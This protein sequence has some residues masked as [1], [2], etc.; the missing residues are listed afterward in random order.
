MR[1]GDEQPGHLVAL[2][3]RDPTTLVSGSMDGA[4]KLWDVAT[5]TARHE[6]KVGSSRV[7]ALAV[8]ADGTLLATT[9]VNETKVRLWELSAG[10]AVADLDAERVNTLNCPLA[11]SPD[12][13]ALYACHPDEVA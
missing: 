7:A 4:V 12:G 5:A 9:C 10:R 8:T 3:F 1:T 13:K 11:F 2:V 6:F